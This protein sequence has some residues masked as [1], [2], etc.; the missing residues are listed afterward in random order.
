VQVAIR[1]DVFDEVTR[2]CAERTPA[3]LRDQLRLEY[4]ARGSSITIVERRAPWNPSFGTDW[5]TSPIA[6]L[7]RDARG[8]W[9]LHWRGS[10][11]R[12]HPYEDVKPTRGIQPL[13]AEIDADP[14]G[15]FWG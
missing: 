14:T 11:E 4:W 6:Q 13:L 12:W 10:D 7:R 3:D 8:A 2:F 9:S 15:I 1:D 5:T